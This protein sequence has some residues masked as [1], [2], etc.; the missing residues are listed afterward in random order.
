LDLLK[1]V[2]TR[3]G[4]PGSYRL[5]GLG[6]GWH[7]HV[8]PPI[9]WILDRLKME[10]VLKPDPTER[11]IGGDFPSD[12]ETMV[13]LVRLDN[14]E[15]CILD[16]L[17]R[18]VPGDLIETGVWRGGAVIFMRAVLKACGDENRVV[19]VADSFQGLPTA[20]PNDRE[21]GA[22]RFSEMQLLSVP[23]DEVRSNFEHYGLLDEQV[24]F[25]AGWFR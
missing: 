15:K 13:G 9:R 3:T 20:M 11:R 25:L 4:F 23:L 16:L 19:W 12:A 6:R 8:L 1:T 14:I 17:E 2:L 10:L 22:D 18:N 5:V 24:R 7:R 21:I